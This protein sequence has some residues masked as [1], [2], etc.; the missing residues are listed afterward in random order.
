MLRPQVEKQSSLGDALEV[1]ALPLTYESWKVAS[2]SP[3][4]KP[5]RVRPRMGFRSNQ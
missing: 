3:V 5:A 4:L 2:M 1:L